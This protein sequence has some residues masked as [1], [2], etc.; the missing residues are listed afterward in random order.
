V[1]Y[2]FFVYKKKCLIFINLIQLKLSSIFEEFIRITV[3]L[4]YNQN[5]YL[6]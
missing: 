4:Q 5:N 3:H 6:E 2:L 1:L